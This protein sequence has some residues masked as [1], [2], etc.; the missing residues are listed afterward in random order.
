MTAPIPS[1]ASPGQTLKKTGDV[2]AFAIDQ[3]FL[4]SQ[5]IK[6]YVRLKPPPEEEAESPED[7]KKKPKVDYKKVWDVKKSGVVESLVQKGVA[8]KVEGRSLFHFDQVFEEMA[9]TPLLYKCFARSMVHTVLN[10][11]H[12]TIFA[13]GQT[14]SGKTF[15]M[16]GDGRVQGGQAGIIQLIASDLFRFMR[17]GAQQSRDFTVKV[18][19]IE[20][21]NERLRDLLSDESSD[22]ASQGTPTGMPSTSNVVTGTTPEV[23]IRTSG[24]GEIALTA[25]TKVVHTSEE[26]LELLLHGNGHRVVARTDMNQ[27]SSRSHAIF[28]ISVESSERDVGPGAE[29]VRVADF[30][31]VDLAGSE[32]TTS[33]NAKRRKEGAKIN[34]SL[35]A[36]S[37]VINALSQPPKKRPKHINYRDSKLTRILQPHLQGNAEMAIICCAS[38]GKSFLEETRSTLMFGARAKLVSVQP[39]VNELN[40]DSALI[41]KLQA[42]LAEAQKQIEEFKREGVPEEQRLNV[43]APKTLTTESTGGS[44]EGDTDEESYGYDDMEAGPGHR[45]YGKVSNQEHPPPQAGPDEA[46]LKA[47]MG[48]RA[49]VMPKN[50]EVPEEMKR[51]HGIDEDDLEGHMEARREIPLNLESPGSDNRRSYVMPEGEDGPQDMDKFLKGR[52]GEDDDSDEDS[53]D[54]PVFQLDAV[55]PG[56]ADKTISRYLKGRT[57]SGDTD[58]MYDFADERGQLS[59]LERLDSTHYKTNS[60]DFPFPGQDR[61]YYSKQDRTG[62]TEDETMDM[63]GPEGSY[64]GVSM[65]FGT[66]YSAPDTIGGVSRGGR[67]NKSLGSGDDI[68]GHENRVSWDTL[69]LATM[70]PEQVGKPLIAMHNIYRRDVPVPDEITI[71][72]LAQAVGDA[73][74]LCLSDKLQE[75][76]ARAAFMET[77]L[78]VADDLVEGIFKDLERAR[79]CIHEMVYRNKQLAEKLKVKHREDVKGEYEAGEFAVEQYWLLKGSMYVGLFFFFTGGHEFFM[80]AVFLVWLILDVNLG[81]TEL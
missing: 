11:K 66:V 49:Y 42:Q 5:T 59:A 25:T 31:L 22:T 38:S 70:R 72:R 60:L 2:G 50:Q 40:D 64:A 17:M 69:D 34:Q 14:G 62:P 43:P 45:E 32:K 39:K 23:Q 78:E 55:D 61:S 8:R 35:L 33:S 51:V 81:N 36:L 63:D 26:I 28:R 12:A 54:R 18:S 52:I 65:K 30:N 44:Q 48:G 47:G 13:Y 74:Q 16:Q 53:E 4:D 76:E 58:D 10:G 77:R 3:K 80:A 19:Y 9:Q 41:K 73:D 27:H 1:S 68:P 29:I 79:L 57:A 21:Y 37:N 75:T 15:T 6:V 56:Q 71:M 46:E 24:T 7:K 67:G 20:V